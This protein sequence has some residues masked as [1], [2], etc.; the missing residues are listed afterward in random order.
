MNQ[1]IQAAFRRY[2]AL[3]WS[4]IPVDTLGL[5]DASDKRPKHPLVSW[6]KYQDERANESAI[7]DWTRRWPKC[8]I[9]I[10]TGRISGIVVIDVDDEDKAGD[11]IESLPITATVKTSKG[12]HYYF[13]YPSYLE[14]EEVVP[15]KARFLPGVDVRGDGG[16]V[17]APPS[18][19]ES[20]AV[21]L[22]QSPPEDQIAELPERVYKKILESKGILEFSDSFGQRKWESALLNGVTEG[23]R[24][25]SAASLIGK[26]LAELRDEA[27]WPLAW[28]AVRAWNQ[29]NQPPLPVK[30]LKTT[31]ESIANRELGKRGTNTPEMVNS[32]ELAKMNFSAP[33]YA[34]AN[35]ILDGTTMLFGKPK[36]GKSWLV[37]QI[38][39]S[40][41]GGW[42]TFPGDNPMFKHNVNQGEVLYL[43]L[44]DSM[45]RLKHRIDAL[46]RGF[47]D[48]I[49]FATRYPQ[50]LQGGIERMRSWLLE[51][52]SARLVVIDSLVAFCGQ[53]KGKGNA[54]TGEYEM[55]RP[56]WEMSQEFKVPILVIHHARK[57]NGFFK[58]GDPHDDTAGT[59]GTNAAVD[60]LIKLDRGFNREHAVLAVAGRDVE[61]HD[62]ILRQI[63][64]QPVWRISNLDAFKAEEQEFKKKAS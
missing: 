20:G 42:R 14:P 48:G 3:G 38:A 58:G 10:V 15:T 19:H 60:T 27:L 12:H 16:M 1:E 21:Y 44:E 55:M 54:F 35:L 41:A 22:W 53:P 18:L 49:H 50:A 8:G 59:L 51:H 23:A 11:L 26:L 9:G 45:S 62:I 13:R 43:A 30:E 37:L 4:V 61:A 36:K 25:D 31:F 64:G 47:P 2:Y 24:N 46:G 28:E 40:V 32:S 6:K 29:L 56:I 39:C 57:S 5:Y 7:H 52:R 17:V 33:G 34:I 63:H